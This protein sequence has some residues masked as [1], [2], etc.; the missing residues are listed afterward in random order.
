M[1]F[2][3]TGWR[4]FAYDPALADWIAA[5]L[6]AARAAV[7]APE[8][9][10]WLRCGGTWFA[11]VNVLE[12]GT[13]GAVAGGPPLSGAAC[14]SIRE[15]LSLGGFAWDRA[16]VSVCYPGYPRPMP[17]ESEAA[18]GYRQRRDAAHVDGLLREGPQRRRFLRQHHAFLLG[19]PMVEAAPDAAPFVLWEGSH[20]IVRTGLA[21]R[22]VGISPDH[23]H[24]V[25][26]TDVYQALRRRVFAECRRV[27]VTAR[28]GEAYLV[29]RL[30]LHGTAP[31]T[32]TEDPG[33]D[34]RMIV[35]FRPELFRPEEWLRLA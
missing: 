11:G 19:I 24:E 15:E 28:P 6:P 35:Y 31:W 2:F 10:R 16:Q 7:R 27:A 34:G 23:W 1:D 13:D 9:A 3:A 12:N 21:N 8:N 17:E 26:L 29:H 25:D 5:A 30:C 22:L 32:A 33:P 14:A 4:R 18:F 20:E